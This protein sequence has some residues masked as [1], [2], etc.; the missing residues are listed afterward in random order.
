MKNL[1]TEKLYIQVF[2]ELKEYI[3][4]NKLG[5]NDKLPTEQQ[6]CDTL[7]VSRNVVREAIK[8]MELMG[9]V[10]TGPGMGSV[11]QEF[12]TDFIFEY[13]FCFLLSE[14]NERIREAL[15]IK[16]ILELSYARS[17]FDLIDDA[18]LKQMRHAWEIMEQNADHLSVY[19]EA[20]KEFHLGIF[21]NLHNR[22]LDSIFNAIWDVDSTFQTERKKKHLAESIS[23]H[24]NILTALEYRDY[25]AFEAAM[26]EHFTT[27]KYLR[28]KGVDVN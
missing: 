26:Q 23:K 16:K 25:A 22:I 27:G 14:D 7:G 12:N 6:L 10:K 4:K 8:A 11:I 15:E 3:V 1:R 17:A 28:T 24:G 19:H 21:K 13:M 2:R 18:S 5:P 20:D 9:I